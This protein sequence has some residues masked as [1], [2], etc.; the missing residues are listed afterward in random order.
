MAAAIDEAGIG[1]FDGD[2]FGAGKPVLYGYGPDADALFKVMEPTL[3]SL[4]F[5]PAHVVVKH[6]DSV[7]G[8]DL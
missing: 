5:R 3:R 1:E 7:S 6:G 4:P 2:A 8:L